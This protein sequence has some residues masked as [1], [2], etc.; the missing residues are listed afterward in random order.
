M[1]AA[2][3]HYHPTPAIQRFRIDS[4]IR[5]PI[6]CVGRFVMLPPM[7]IRPAILADLDRLLEIDATIESTRYLHVDRSGEALASA[8]RLDERPLRAK[9]IDNNPPTDDLRFALRQVLSGVEEGAAL[10][11]EH[12]GELVALA[13]GQ[14][15][16]AA[17]TLRL[18]D[19]RV[20]YDQRR[21][22]IGSAMLYQLIATA[23]ERGCRAVTA[24]TLTNNV[25]ANAFLAKAAFELGGLDTH[26]LSNHDLV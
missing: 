14:F 8:W 21:Q 22:G 2:P 7:E 23:R 25:T 10:A 11:A 18:L 6:S 17:T 15:D 26:F 13:V 1:F 24:H 19:L 3:N 4:T 20:D 12:D 5:C 9:L 16:P